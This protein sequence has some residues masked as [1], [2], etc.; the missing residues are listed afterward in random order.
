MITGMNPVEVCS[1]L[2]I[3]PIMEEVENAIE[4]LKNNKSASSTVKIWW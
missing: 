4:K 3:S 1:C 2:H